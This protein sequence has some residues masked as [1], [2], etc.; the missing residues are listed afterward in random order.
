MVSQKLLEASRVFPFA[1]AMQLAT[2]RLPRPAVISIGDRTAADYH[3][4][5]CRTQRASAVPGLS[6]AA[7]WSSPACSEAPTSGALPPAARLV[8]SQAPGVVHGPPNTYLSALLYVTGEV[9][10]A[11]ASF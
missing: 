10:S 7:A 1:A 2:V 6:L 4:H 5:S 11:L 9:V 3:I 8:P